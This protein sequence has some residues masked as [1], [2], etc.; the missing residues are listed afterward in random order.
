MHKKYMHDDLCNER[1]NF[2]E[3]PC[4]CGQCRHYI[5]NYCVR[6]TN[7]VMAMLPMNHDDFCSYGVSSKDYKRRESLRFN[8]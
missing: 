7:N 4:R 5:A 8:E 3:V 1:F 2:V 6:E